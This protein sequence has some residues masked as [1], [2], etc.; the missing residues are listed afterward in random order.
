MRS[1]LVAPGDDEAGLAAAL[2][3]PADAVV[4]DLDVARR[5][6]AR[7][8]AGRALR[9]AAGRPGGPVLMARVRP[10]CAIGTDD[11]LDAVMAAAPR[12]IV[13][14]GARGRASLQQLSAKLTLR[15]AVFDLDDG[16]TGIIAVVDS[17]EALLT[18]AGLRGAC[19]RLIGLVW[20]AETLR[21][22]VGAEIARGADGEFVG[23]LRLAREMTLLGAA[24]AGVPA[25]DT[26][27]PDPW[28]SD[29]ARFE[30]LAARRAGFVGKVVIDPAQAAIVNEVFG[31]AGQSGR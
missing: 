1:L 13:L 8:N 5:D 10:L 6:A 27:L 16:A 14:P 19:A 3:G 12:A 7:A 21:I 23:P 26:A 24:A 29:D 11:D 17:A 4:V 2:A 25:I 18:L 31:A 30:A 9:E 28:S 15:E 20:D 22:E